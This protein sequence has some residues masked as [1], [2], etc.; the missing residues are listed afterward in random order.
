[1]ATVITKHETAQLARKQWIQHYADRVYELWLQQE[2]RFDMTPDYLQQIE[3][4]LAA[5]YEHPLKRTFIEA[6]Y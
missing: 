3:T 5:L 2:A 6:T 1:M 4:D